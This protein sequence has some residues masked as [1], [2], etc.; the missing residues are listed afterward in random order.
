MG[1][2]YI[3]GDGSKGNFTV[4]PGPRPVALK[5]TLIKTSTDAKGFFSAE[6]GLQD[7]GSNGCAIRAIR[8][9]VQHK[10]GNWHT[11]EMNN[12]VDNRFWWNKDAVQG[13]IDAANFFN[14]PV[15]IVIFAEAIVS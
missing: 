13:L 3:A 7:F 1:A 9:S 2:C 6:H 11:L 4:L 8:V 5:T 15:Q 10:N 14:Q 12:F